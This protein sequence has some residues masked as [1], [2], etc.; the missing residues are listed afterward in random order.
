MWMTFSLDTK[1]SLAT[2][3]KARACAFSPPRGG[4]D[5]EGASKH[6]RENLEEGH[7]AFGIDDGTIEVWNDGLRRFIERIDSTKVQTGVSIVG[8][9]VE[10]KT[11]L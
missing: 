5:S 2:K 7:V 3:G 6:A 1:R 11:S 9:N 10:K 8:D 4:D